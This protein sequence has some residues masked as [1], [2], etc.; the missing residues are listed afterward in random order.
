VRA[1]RVEAWQQNLDGG[2][3]LQFAGNQEDSRT[4][5]NFTRTRCIAGDDARHPKVS[6]DL[7]SQDS[8]G[9]ICSNNK[10]SFASERTNDLTTARGEN[11]RNLCDGMAR[12]ERH[13]RLQ[14][15]VRV[16]AT[17]PQE[18]PVLERSSG[19][20]KFFDPLAGDVE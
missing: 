11:L 10:I 15:L 9:F 4:G 6:T 8:D 18:V 16:L 14:V 17:L 2:A 19:E 5:W 12:L 13:Q 7:G 3:C 1:S 20:Q